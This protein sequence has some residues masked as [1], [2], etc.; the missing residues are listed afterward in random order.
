MKIIKK[1][2]TT[3]KFRCKI[4]GCIFIADKNEYSEKI[5]SE[6]LKSHLFTAKCPNCGNNVE[7]VKM[8]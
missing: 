4:C 3:K 2:K 7:D 6:I 8:G 1:G 5:I